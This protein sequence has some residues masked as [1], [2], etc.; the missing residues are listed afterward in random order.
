MTS[1]AEQ[2]ARLFDPS[3]KSIDPEDDIYEETRAKVVEKDDLNS[4]A[5]DGTVIQHVPGIGR[6]KM[7]SLE[8]M[9]ELYRGKVVSRNQTSD[10]D[11]SESGNEDNIE[12]ENG[13]AEDEN[14]DS[15][16]DQTDEDIERE[17]NGDTSYNSEVGDIMLDEDDG[18]DEEID[19]DE[20]DG[21]GDDSL[22][23]F[24]NRKKADPLLKSRATRNQFCLW[25]NMLEARIKFQKILTISNRL[26]QYDK[27]ELFKTELPASLSSADKILSNLL[28][29]LL[30][31]E[32]R[33]LTQNP[34]TQS[35]ADSKISNNK[36]KSTTSM[37]EVNDMIQDRFTS[38]KTH[39]NKVLKL[40]Y[41]K[42]RLT[43]TSKSKSFSNFER[44]TVSQI[45]DILQDRE[46]L[47]KRTQLKRTNYRILGT[48]QSNKLETPVEDA[49]NH[50]SHLKE[51]LPEI[52]DDDDFYHQ[53][54]RQLI[55]QKSSGPG[56]SSDPVELTRQWLKVQRLRSK[57]KKNVDTKASKGRKIRYEIH[58]KLQSF[59][60]PN[61][62]SDFTH[63]A[64]NQLFMSLFGNV[65]ECSPEI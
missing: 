3:V 27:M 4:D 44:S 42:T 7:Q 11:G 28:Y 63:E 5:E 46:R 38:Y 54:L 6:R 45:E 59:M 60:A 39:R 9:G 20:A 49:D 29:K 53:L 52:Y 32:R 58:Q 18:M 50:S 51:Y 47:I 41:D 62:Q 65:P 21:D 25:E 33:L 43:A 13:N 15:G 1:L 56:G 24:Q 23:I 8:G 61:D 30:E 40:W 12:L 31:L 14:I 48:T 34:E 17:M 16:D 36:R 2:L 22:K 35:I 64:R 26:P 55:E 19:S 57:A 37:E 10:G